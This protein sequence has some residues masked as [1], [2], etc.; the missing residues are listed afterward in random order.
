MII[1]DTY[2]KF[3]KVFLEILS[4]HATLK[5]KCVIKSCVICFKSYTESY[6]E[7]LFPGKNVPKKRTEK[8]RRLT[9][10]KKASRRYKEDRY[11]IFSNLNPSFVTDNKLFWKTIKLFFLTERSW[12]QY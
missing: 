12:Y 1:I 8:S 9:K 11:K 7:K 4:K 2:D 5:N 6:Y 10:N 3:D